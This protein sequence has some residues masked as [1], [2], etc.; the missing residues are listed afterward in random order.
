MRG[1]R[2]RVKTTYQN[3]CVPKFHQL[4]AQALFCLVCRNLFLQFAL[5]DVFAI[6][7]CC[8]K[9]ECGLCILLQLAVRRERPRGREGEVRGDCENDEIRERE[10]GVRLRKWKN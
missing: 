10:G 3:L 5:Q 8:R 6:H 7:F 1:G 9:S 4:V 2:E